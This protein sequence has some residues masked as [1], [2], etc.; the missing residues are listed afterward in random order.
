[1]PEQ[2]VLL[3]HGDGA[4][5]SVNIPD[6]AIPSGFPHIATVNGNAQID[7]A[8]K[9]I[10]NGSIL[11]DG[12]GDYLTVPDSADWHF[13]S[14]DFT[15]ESYVRRAVTGTEHLVVSQYNSSI[16]E[17]SFWFGIDADH[18]RFVAYSTG[19]GTAI[20][21]LVGTT[22]VTASEWHHVAVTR[23]GNN[24]YLFLDGLLED[25]DAASGTLF[26]ASTPLNIG[27]AIYSGGS[28]SGNFN[29]HI[30]E[31]RIS[32]GIA[33][34]TANFTAPTS[35]LHPHNT[36]P[37]TVLLLHMDGADASTKIPDYA[38]GGSAP[39][40]VTCAA[41]AQLDT[42]QYKFGPTSCLFDGTGDYLSVPGSVDWNLGTA[43]TIEFWVRGSNGNN[44]LGWG[45]GGNTYVYVSMKDGTKWN[46]SY[47]SS[48]VLNWKCRADASFIADTWTHVAISKE[49]GGNVYWF[50]NGVKL[51]NTDGNGG[52]FP[53]MSSKTFYVGATRNDAGIA[54][55][56]GHID[57]LR[58]SKGIARYTSNFTPP[59]SK[60]TQ[61]IGGT[62]SSSS[63][64]SLSSSSSSAT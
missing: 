2:T 29:G 45:D 18:I 14:G 25:S 24:W 52:D 34:Y 50:I 51:T 11:F 28:P 8:Q 20:L 30:D 64:I 48:G 54:Y 53:D 27:M 40:Q 1:V 55:F 21:T 49:T 43:F 19:T 39:H 22:T 46:I 4:D 13:G 15:I 6:A 62:S 16:N 33:R 32:K 56:T 35:P 44:L 57:E 61:Y 38:L 59:T 9:K 60:F 41:D 26:D 42:A 31:L 10:G 7:T 23:S 58:I 36:D 12:T 3:L 17:V 5:A 47:V 37:N 63:S